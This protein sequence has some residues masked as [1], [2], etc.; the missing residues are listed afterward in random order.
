MF[1]CRYV[2]L[3][4]FSSQNSGQKFTIHFV[5]VFY[6][7][8]K[9]LPRFSQALMFSFFKKNNSALQPYFLVNL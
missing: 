6:K 9:I 3:T 2:F 8:T 1:H 5:K 4:T 7:W